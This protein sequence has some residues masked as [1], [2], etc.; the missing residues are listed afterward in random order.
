MCREQ[1]CTPLGLA[2]KP[3]GNKHGCELPKSIRLA[4]TGEGRK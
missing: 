4:G 3:L 1:T 2:Y